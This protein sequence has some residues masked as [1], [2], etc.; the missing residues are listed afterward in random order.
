MAPLK[1]E[2]IFLHVLGPRM[3]KIWSNPEEIS[4]IQYNKSADTHPPLPV[5]NEIC[6]LI[7]W[8]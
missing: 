1:K 4:I 5:Q 2:T 3:Y 8:T 6:K 7:R